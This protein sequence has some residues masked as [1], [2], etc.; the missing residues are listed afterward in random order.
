MLICLILCVV[1]IVLSL[2]SVWYGES[3]LLLIWVSLFLLKD[4]VMCLGVFGV[5][6]GLMVMVYICL[7][8]FCYGFLSLLF[9][10]EMCYVFVLWL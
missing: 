8:G 9:L 7:V 4:R 5:F 2:I 6:L 10:C 3:V 1:V